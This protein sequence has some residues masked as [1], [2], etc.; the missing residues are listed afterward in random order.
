MQDVVFSSEEF[1]ATIN[2]LLKGPPGVHDE[3]ELDRLGRLG[4]EGPVCDRRRGVVSPE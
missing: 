1:K 2:R 3:R 4:A